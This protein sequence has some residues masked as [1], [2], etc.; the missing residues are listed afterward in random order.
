MSEMHTPTTAPYR[1]GLPPVP[2]RLRG[3]PIVRGYPVPW[4]VAQ[5]PD[6]GYDFRV[7]DGRKVAVAIREQRCWVCGQRLGAFKAFTLGP[8]CAVNRTAAEPPAHAEC[9]HWSAA[10][11]PFL[12]QTQHRRREGGLPETAPPPGE[13]LTRQPG[14]ALVWI[15]KTFTLFDDGKG[16]TL[17]E[18]DE[19]TQTAWYCQGRAATRAEVLASIESGLP[20]LRALAEQEGEAALAALAA[21]VAR[22]MRYVPA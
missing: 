6:G 17:I 13:M 15:T 19:P 5:L 16:G 8:M 4:F 2:A 9:A 3:R 1:P 21:H 11:C 22:A 20:A 10:A 18:I 12:N 14:V 7:A